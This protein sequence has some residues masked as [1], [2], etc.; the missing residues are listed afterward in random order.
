MQPLPEIRD[1]LDRLTRLTGGDTDMRALL[2]SIVELAV[3][4]VP[5]C[6]GVSI[7]I[8]ADGG[9]FT[10]TATTDDLGVVD[11]AQ[12]LDGGPCVACAESGE[13]LYVPDIL[14]EKRWQLA[15]QVAAAKGVRSSLS[16][17]LRDGVEVIGALNLYSS[18]ADGFDRKQR[19][20]AG[21][22]G[23]CVDEVVSNA[24]LSFMTRDFAREL[25]ERLAA[26]SRVDEAVGMLMAR[27]GWTSAEAR[28]RLAEAAARAGVPPDRLAE[29]LVELTSRA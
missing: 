11:A 5:T 29:V 19:L 25:P 16:L 23:A 20:I 12:Y 17:P 10:I 2:G 28:E 22:F 6:T 24:D 21:I 15:G 3:A 27:N 18:E 26:S 1:A 9:P 13:D 14:D 4:V 8:T 7:T